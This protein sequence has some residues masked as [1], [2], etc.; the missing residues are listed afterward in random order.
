[1]IKRNLESQIKKYAEQ[2]PVLSIVGPRQSGKTTL[3]R[4]LFPDYRYVSLENLDIRS[5]GHDDP[6]GFLHDYP[7]PVIIDE[8]QRVPH[9]FSYLQEKVDL[10]P[11]PA[12]YILTGSQ[13]FL[14]MESIS[15]SLA[16][17]V[18]N[19][20]LYPFTYNELDGRPE[21]NSLEEIFTI[22]KDAACP[23]HS[24]EDIL[25]TGMYPRIHDKKLSPRKWLENYV[26]TYIE[27]DIRQLVNVSNLRTFESFLKI[28]A[29][30]SGQLINFS[31]LSDL[32]GISL[33]T[34][35]S[36]ISLLETSGIIFILPPHH[37]SFS[38]R[39][40][41]TPKL[42][43]NDTGLLCFLLSVRDSHDLKSHPLYGNIFETFVIG[44]FYKRICHIA[45]IPP[46]YFW[47]D[48]TGNEIDLV[49]DFGNKLFPVEIKASRTYSASFKDN[50]VKWLELKGN[51]QAEGLILFNGEG[52]MGSQSSIPAAPWWQL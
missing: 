49:V 34:A 11:A 1:M 48:K 45:E 42:F 8:I 20:K 5:L 22:K 12:Q 27:R 37:R 10:N 36:W 33:P 17:R 31:S 2:Y 46:L 41:K 32:T 6:R 35:K 15:Q 26:L 44:E 38:K 50:I 29:S 28:I 4:Y 40:V 24:I 13:Q 39:V 43:F 14:L 51:T 23:S 21:D 25:F 16:G 18:I 9:L 19:F 52:V 3:A 47:R 7:P 30:Q